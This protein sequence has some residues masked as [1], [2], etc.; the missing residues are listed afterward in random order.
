ML[1][2]L[3]SSAIIGADIQQIVG[4]AIAFEILFKTPLWLGSILT[5]INAFG[6]LSITS[7]FQSGNHQLEMLVSLFIFTM[8]I[9]FLATLSQTGFNASD[10]ARGLL[11]PS[12]PEYGV[13]QAVGLLG[14][15]VSPHNLF[16]HSH[17]VI[18]AAAVAATS[19]A[20]QQQRQDETEKSIYYATVECSIT[21]FIAFIINMCVVLTFAVA[22]FDETCATLDGGPFAKLDNGGE[23]GDIGLAGSGMVLEKSLGISARYIWAIGLLAAGQASTL[24]GTMAGSIVFEGFLELD[25]PMWQRMLIGRSMSL[26][27]ALIVA[28]MANSDR[29]LADQV[30]ELL[31]VLQ[32]VVLP[33]ALIPVLR[34]TNREE[35]MGP[36]FKN[37]R[38]RKLVGHSVA[39]LIL[40]INFVLI[41]QNI[42][43][44]N[45]GTVWN[46]F[47]SVAFAA[48]LAFVAWVA[49]ATLTMESEPMQQ[50]NTMLEQGLL[51]RGN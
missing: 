23:C 9:C 19:V 13:V 51:G 5:A 14:A 32:N 48:Y 31:N 11:V 1:F 50:S 17:L 46:A 20:K 21:L 38:V 25:I 15:T 6:L 28:L 4:S 2:A 27:P 18:P 41:G 43:M 33:F 40:G 42:V 7:K 24:T 36:Y 35:I 37:G 26:V 49:C 30:D 44:D 34:L 29:N 16:L 12:V 39:I 47:A 10:T 22:F 8:L 3:I 45:R